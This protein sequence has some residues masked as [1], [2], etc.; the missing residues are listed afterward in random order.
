MNAG[1]AAPAYQ[2]RALRLR[3]AVPCEPEWV[4]QQITAAAE[5]GFNQ[6]IVD[7]FFRGITCFPSRSCKQFGLPRLHSIFHKTDFLAVAAE[8]AR[9]NE[10][11]L[12]A[13]IDCLHCGSKNDTPRSPINARGFRVWRNASKDGWLGMHREG[14]TDDVLLCPSNPDVSDFL[15]TLA[16]ELTDAYP[17]DGL[18][19][20]GLQFGPKGG[21]HPGRCFCASCVHSSD[22]PAPD[23]ASDWDSFR[24]KQLSELVGRIKARARQSR[25]TLRLWGQFPL[26]PGL[27]DEQLVLRDF[28]QELFDVD[29]MPFQ[30]SDDL[31]PAHSVGVEVAQ[32]DAADEASLVEAVKLAEVS[33]PLGFVC[34]WTS[35]HTPD[36][37]LL[38][39]LAAIQTVPPDRDPLGAARKWLQLSAQAGDAEPG[40][41]ARQCLALWE[42]AGTDEELPLERIHAIIEP[43]LPPEG[44][45]EPVEREAQALARAF[46][47][48]RLAIMVRE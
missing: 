9:R 8:S 14:D 13:A 4:D 15:G 24:L 37:A 40:K 39:E 7:A 30:P 19:L 27:Q 32:F 21:T 45:D 29:V 6:V 36:P 16:A 34:R 20:N 43:A 31:Q 11:H 25:R 38:A 12:V 47:L 22:F 44:S 23:S 26:L 48:L 3:V 41:R 10:L 42:S 46:A 28:D 33:F 17:L 5:A 35:R 2:I 18:L 1:S